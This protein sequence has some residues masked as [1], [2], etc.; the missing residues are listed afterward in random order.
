MAFQP[1][2]IADDLAE[3]WRHC[4][5]DPWAVMWRFTRQTLPVV[6]WARDYAR[7]RT[8]K[9]ALPSDLLAAFTGVCVVLP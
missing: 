1:D 7:L 6:D 8:I 3:W 2:L 9:S 4:R 5:R